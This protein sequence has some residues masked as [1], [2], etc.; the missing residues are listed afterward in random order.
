MTL[1]LTLLVACDTSPAIDEVAAECVPEGHFDDLFVFEA[2]TSGEVDDVSLRMVLQGEEWSLLP[3]AEEDTDY[4]TG[5]M[6]GS[7]ANA[8]C[9]ELEG[10]TYRFIATGA[11]GTEATVDL[12][13]ETGETAE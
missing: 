1:L 11:D 8:D 7:T 13:A 9:R 4:W 10:I 2:W 5:E 6:W 3:L 12:D